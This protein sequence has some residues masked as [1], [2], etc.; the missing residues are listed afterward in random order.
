MRKILSLVIS[1]VLAFGMFSFAYANEIVSPGMN[2]N[3]TSVSLDALAGMQLDRVHKNKISNEMDALRR[4][5]IDTTLINQVDLNNG[6]NVYE[7]KIGNITDYVTVNQISDDEVAYSVREGNISNTV[8]K[9][10]DGRVLVDGKEVR[11]TSS[12]SSNSSRSGWTSTKSDSPMDG[13]SESD[14][15]N[16]LSSGRSNAHMDEAVGNLTVSALATVIG[17]FAPF[18]G[19]AMTFAWSV[20]DVLVSINP[21]TKEVSCTYDTYTADPSNYQYRTKVFATDNYTGAYESM[22]TYEHFRFI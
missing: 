10:A 17:L 21:D 6:K 12:R 5:S 4:C 1:A 19:A 9:K 2:A 3:K 8:V 7:V 18:V 22:N 13:L 16:Y 20:K 15:T 14:Y 11:Y